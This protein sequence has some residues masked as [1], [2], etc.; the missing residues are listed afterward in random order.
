MNPTTA[1]PLRPHT[2]YLNPQ[3]HPITPEIKPVSSSNGLFLLFGGP[4]E[5]GE[6]E[7]ARGGDVFEVRRWCERGGYEG[8][9]EVLL[10]AVVLEIL[11]SRCLYFLWSYSQNLQMI[12]SN[13]ITV[14][15][16]SWSTKEAR[17][18]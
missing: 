5:G 8:G 12:I 7:Q 10:R 3:Y 11:E 9:D 6:A 17:V 4:E 13:L 16:S 14:I 2:T 18:Q 15:S 1:R